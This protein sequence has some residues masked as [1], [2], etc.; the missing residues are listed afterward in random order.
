MPY[1]TPHILHDKPL[2]DDEKAHFHFEEFAITLARLAA[3]TDTDTPVTVGISG[4]WG[5][6][7]TT[8]LK[9]TKSLLDDEKGQQL[10]ANSSDQGK[11]REL[12]FKSQVQPGS[13]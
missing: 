7:K 6:G 8:L 11:F 2:G 4:L 12:G 3:S 5:S 13:N 9:R 1:V 10:F